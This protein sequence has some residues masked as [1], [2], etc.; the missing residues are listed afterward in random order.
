MLMNTVEVI[1]RI[2]EGPKKLS[3]VFIIKIKKNIQG[4]MGHKQVKDLLM[5]N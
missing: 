4:S 3:S 5:P 2:K 1:N